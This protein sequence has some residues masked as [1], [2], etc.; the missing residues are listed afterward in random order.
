M[1]R[2]TREARRRA[3]AVNGKR[4]EL[5][6]FGA[7][8]LGRKLKSAEAFPLKQCDHVEGGTTIW[9]RRERPDG[10]SYR[11]PLIKGGTRCPNTALAGKK[12]LEHLG[13]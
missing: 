8:G 11:I 9:L 3:K 1:D 13:R 6:Q 2:Q 5:P 4:G 7:R 12:C 10:T